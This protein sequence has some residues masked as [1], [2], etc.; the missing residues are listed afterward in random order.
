MPA[1]KPTNPLSVAMIGLLLVVFGIVDLLYVN[2]ALGTLLT[3]VG[4]A[5]GIAGLTRYRTLKRQ[6]AERKKDGQA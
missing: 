6:L 3:A 5:V 1:K 4:V 2:R